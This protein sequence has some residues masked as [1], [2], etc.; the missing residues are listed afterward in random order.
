MYI[1]DKI[2]KFL[3]MP[4]CRTYA[5]LFLGDK[6]C[7]MIMRCLC[8]PYFLFIHRYWPDFKKP[9]TFSEKTF[10]RMLYC[11][12][13]KLT[14]I[15]DKLRVRDYIAQKVSRDYLIPLLWQGDNPEDIPFDKLPQKFVIK[16]NHGC[17]YNIIVQDK[18]KLDTE[19]CKHQLYAWLSENF[20]QDKYLGIAWAYKNI[21]PKILIEKF[22]EDNGQVPLDYKYFC[23]AGRAEFIQVSFGRYGDASER[24]LDRNFIS[25]DVWNGLKLY[26]GD[27]TR[28]HNYDEMLHLADSLSQEFDFIRVDLY[29]IG[30]R[31]YFGELTC[32]PAGGLAPF[33]PKEYDYIFGEKWVIK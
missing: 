18:V 25:V 12:N 11:R 16:T 29:S 9:R 30:S 31:I 20:C 21:K 5:R 15:S 7:D 3:Y 14:L 8:I 1:L 26:Q 19:K 23:F 6:P 10:N 27:I 13:P 28:P 24:I 32:Y 22:I 33:I 4:I 17:G 2:F